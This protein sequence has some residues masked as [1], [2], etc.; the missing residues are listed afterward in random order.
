MLGLD[1]NKLEM[2]DNLS[3]QIP[4]F[5]EHFKK[6]DERLENDITELRTTCRNL[7][8]TKANKEQVELLLEQIN[9][10]DS[11]L[12]RVKTHG[13]KNSHNMDLI[14]NEL[15]DKINGI[16]I[17]LN[18]HGKQIEEATKKNEYLDNQ[19]NYMRKKIN[20]ME[21]DLK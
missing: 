9:K 11:D 16:K 20:K 10:L 19:L 18:D 14:K 7:G 12:G 1:E 21:K 15:S 4:K 2:I 3:W 6:I 13:Q 5:K 8:E 17:S